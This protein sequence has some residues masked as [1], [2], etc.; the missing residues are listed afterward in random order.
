M[1]MALLRK[2]TL[3]VSIS[4]VSTFAV[5]L[6]AALWNGD[7]VRWLL[8]A[9]C[10]FQCAL[11]FLMMDRRERTYSKCCRVCDKGCASMCA[12]YAQWYV[13]TESEE[14]HTLSHGN[15]SVLS[16]AAFR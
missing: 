15:E 11:I 6:C 7:V 2:H 16:N 9:D 4:M 12:R 13:S 5:S 14:E 8:H 1:G 10:V 3:L